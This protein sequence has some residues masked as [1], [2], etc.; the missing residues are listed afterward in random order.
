VKKRRLAL[1]LLVVVLALVAGTVAVLRTRWA[2]QR[3]CALAAERVEAA[4][5]LAVA[6]QACRIEPLSLLLEVQVSGPTPETERRA[7]LAAAEHA[8][9]AEASLPRIWQARLRPVSR[10]AMNGC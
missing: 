2:G 9:L 1:V 3:I 6:V 4:T 5:G 8:V 10:G 7:V